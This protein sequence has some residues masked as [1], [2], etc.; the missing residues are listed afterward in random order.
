MS[1]G[2]VQRPDGGVGDQQ[3]VA[4]GDG[5]VELGLELH[6]RRQPMKIG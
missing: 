2:G 3:D 1:F 6:A 5:P 4:R